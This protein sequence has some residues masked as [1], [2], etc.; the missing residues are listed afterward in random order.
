MKPLYLLLFLSFPGIFSLNAQHQNMTLLRQL[1]DYPQFGYTDCWGY[2]TL[3]GEHFAFLGVNGGVS[4]V[5][6]TDQAT[7]AEVDFIPFVNAGWYDMKTF[8]NYLYVSSE[9]SH[10]VL[11]ADLSPLPDSVRVV[12]FYGN[13]PSD[14]HN[15]FIDT[16]AGIL[17][18]VED[19]NF[20]RSVSLHSLNDPENPVEIS[21]LG[22]GLGADAHDVFAQNGR[23]YVAEGINGSIGI[24]DIRNP[25]QPVL[26][27]RLFIP[28]P[29]YVHNVWTSEDDRYLISTEETAG[30][31]VKIW[32]ISD[33]NAIP[34]VDE[35][36]GESR[37]AHNAYIRGDY[38]FISHYQSGI[39]VLDIADPSNVIE[40]GH[41]DTFPQGE[42]SGFSGNWG[43]YPFSQNGLVYVSDMQSGLYVL[44]FNH[45]RAYRVVGVVKDAATG[46]VIAGALI[47]PDSATASTRTDP[48][49]QFKTGV[50]TAGPLHLKVAA[51]GFE[52]ATLALTAMPGVSDTIEV[53]LQPSPRSAIVGKVSGPAG[54]PLAGRTLSLLIESPLLS[55]SLLLTTQSDDGGEYI[56]PDLPVMAQNEVFYRR[57]QVHQFF[58]YPTESVADI[59]LNPDF[60]ATVDFQLHPADLL[61][62]NDDPSGSF[63]G[64]FRESLRGV[65]VQA[66]E[67]FTN[68]D[69]E[70]FPAGRIG[71]LKSP[72][73]IWFSGESESN[74][75]TAAG[76]DSLRVVL[77]QG[78]NLLLTGQNIAE[79]LNTNGVD[80]LSGVLGVGYEGLGS[81]PPLIRPNELNPVFG[82]LPPFQ[83]SQ[84]SR[85]AL[86]IPGPSN[87]SAAFHFI[88]GKIAGITREDPD[89]GSKLVFLGFGLEGVVQAE[90]RTSILS[91]ALHWF[92]VITSLEE[93][94]G[95]VPQFL[96]LAQNFPNPFNPAT[97]IPYRLNQPARIKLTVFDLLGQ[98]VKTLVEGPQAAGSYQVVWDG[99]DARGNPAASG[100]YL[101]RLETGGFS[102][103]RKM[104]LLR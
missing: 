32:D 99:T 44:E 65:S 19:F 45:A 97:Q 100:V 83:V 35:Y 71:E 85:D 9:G 20:S 54:Q 40:V 16:A 55:D 66:F 25:A 58:P 56:F 47:T 52:S 102:H 73:V 67:W 37:L 50:A 4:V 95:N 28:A 60:P 48:F 103:V 14:P 88:N 1:N 96:E 61:L 23:L 51:F 27:Q 21:V 43:V 69:N 30:K 12:G 93:S 49:G 101:Y 98:P 76:Q 5:R 81:G 8:G 68:G 38:A 87:A 31:T 34:L 13:F 92:H 72:T 39:K 91:A 63:M 74:V 80:F 33:L 62:V 104:I 82:A 41:Y 26:L 42:N 6:T 2:S 46:A 84:P 59:S 29:G 36:L 22:P 57:V 79:D 70:V 11:I 89:K 24:F 7:I 3:G 64:E 94:P 53:N 15:I 86:F 75:I 18:V 78:G 77:Q 10:Q 90:D 17:F